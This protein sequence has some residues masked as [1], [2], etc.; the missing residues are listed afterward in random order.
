MV[1]GLFDMVV[2]VDRDYQYIIA[3]RSFLNYR[4]MEREQVLGHRVDEILE[5]DVFESVV[6]GRWTSVCGGKVVQYELKYDY[7]DPGRAS[8][9]RVVLPYRWSHGIDRI[10]CV[11]RDV[12][13]AKRPERAAQVRRQVQQSFSPEVRWQSQSR[14]KPMGRI[15]MQTNIS[16]NDLASLARM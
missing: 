16:R 15:W 11:L 13:R 10:A 14:R 6:K 9:V 5:K 8:L 4:N 12:T 2:V 7:P 1:E 3:N